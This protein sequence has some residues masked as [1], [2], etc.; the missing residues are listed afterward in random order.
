MP[1]PTTYFTRDEFAERQARVRAALGEDGLET[2][3]HVPHELIV[4]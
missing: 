1:E 4:H 2:I 3:T